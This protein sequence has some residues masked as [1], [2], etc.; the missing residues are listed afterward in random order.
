MYTIY[1][2]PHPLGVIVSKQSGGAGELLLTDEHC[3]SVSHAELVRIAHTTRVV[4]VPESASENCPLR[5][6]AR[7]SA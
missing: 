4:T 2:R 6:F 5:R 7:K 3:C 1:V